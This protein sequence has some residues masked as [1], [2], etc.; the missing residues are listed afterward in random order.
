MAEAGFPD[1]A[2]SS[3]VVPEG[4]RVVLYEHPNFGGKSY[5]INNTKT[6]F[7]ISGWNDKTSSIRV[8]RD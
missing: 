3:L 7:Y 1:D 4:Y 8:Y 2:L 6:Q 5:T